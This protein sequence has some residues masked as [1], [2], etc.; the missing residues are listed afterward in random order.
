VRPT[1]DL[2]FGIGLRPKHYPAL[3]AALDGREAGSG[4][5]LDRIDW[6]EVISEN[7]FGA[8]GNPRRM[9]NKIRQRFP[10]VLHGVTLSLGSTDPLDQRYLDRLATLAQEIEPAF[11]S[12]HLC[13]GG[14][15]GRRA[16]D[17]LPLPFSEEALDLV[18]ARIGQVQDQLRRPFVVE[19]VSSYVSFAAS[20][21]PEWEFLGELCARTGCKLLL[22]VNNVFVS[23]HNHGFDAATFITSLPAGAVAQIHLAGH[24]TRGQLLLDTHDHAIREEVWQ[25]YQLAITAHGPTPTLIEWDDQIPALDEVVAES[26]RARTRSL[27]RVPVPV[28]VSLPVPVPDSSPPL[29]ELQSRFFALVTAREDVPGALERLALTPAAAEALSPGDARLDAVG[30]IGIYND[31]YFLRLLDV[32]RD[33]FAALAAVLGEDDYRTLVADYLEAHPP[34]D[35][36]LRDLGGALPA[37]VTTHHLLGQ[38]PWLAEL[39]AFEWA[40]ADV[41]DARDADALTLADVQAMPPDDIASLAL[42]AVPGFRLVDVGHSVD[43]TWR[44]V[45]RDLDLV[46]PRPEPLHLVVWR[47]GM[48]VVHRRAGA[49]ERALLPSL[50]AGTTFGALCDQLGQQDDA[51]GVEEAAQTAFQ[52]LGSW[53]SGGL[54]QR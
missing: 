31:M 10:V 35:H 54:L 42:R 41:F 32:L 43:E 36:S 28:P 7:Y 13:W 39:A 4:G 6:F 26:D 38:R 21:M 44:S 11:V 53:L 52:L 15:G 5:V 29:R 46:L 14:V 18:S 27:T 17:L 2:G 33:D 16:H 37:F 22:D 24:S 8:G 20:T 51:T 45:D 34:R 40:R 19:N 48:D 25:L 49:V 30:R 47:A 23:A 9:L 12:D 50:I 3:E 1:A